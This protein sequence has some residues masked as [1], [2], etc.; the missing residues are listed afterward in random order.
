MPQPVRRETTRPAGQCVRAFAAHASISHT[1]RG[2]WAGG[3]PGA[4][5]SGSIHATSLTITHAGFTVP[6]ATGIVAQGSTIW[7]VLSRFEGG[8]IKGR[9]SDGESAGGWASAPYPQAIAVADGF[10]YVA[11]RD[12]SVEHGTIR[13]HML[14]TINPTLE[15]EILVSGEMDPTALTLDGDWLYWVNRSNGLVRKMSRYGGIPETLATS[16]G[17][18][19]LAVDATHVYVADFYGLM[20]VAK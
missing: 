10:A 17:L 9:L 16:L 11:A 14:R 13:K 3:H 7:W 19:A 18:A 2:G 12:H 4:H 20:R 6:G 15:N 5:G 8:F 1:R